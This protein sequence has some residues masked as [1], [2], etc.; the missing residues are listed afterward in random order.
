MFDETERLKI[1]ILELEQEVRDLKAELDREEQAHR[2]EVARLHAQ[3]GQEA[4]LS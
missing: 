3:L 1:R 4:V 2:D